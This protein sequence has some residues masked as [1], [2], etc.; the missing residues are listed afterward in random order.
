MHEKSVVDGSSGRGLRGSE[1]T[2]CQFVESCRVAEL[3]RGMISLVLSCR[4][5]SCPH[6][7]LSFLV[8]ASLVIVFSSLGFSCLRLLLSC[9]LLACLLLCWLLWSF[10]VSCLVP[11]CLILPCIGFSGLRIPFFLPPNILRL[12]LASLVF[13]F[14]W[15]VPSCLGWS[16][17]SVVLASLAFVF[18]S[19]LLS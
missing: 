12:V 4:L 11:S 6:L 8:L 2:F 3:V 17:S 13:V 5:F 19:R 7:V 16:S 1:K 15:P 9:P 18:A 14:S 10:V